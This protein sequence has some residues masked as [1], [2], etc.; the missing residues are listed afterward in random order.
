MARRVVRTWSGEREPVL[1]IGQ[2]SMKTG[3][4]RPGRAKAVEVLGGVNALSVE[5]CEHSPR[6]IVS[7]VPRLAARGCDD[8][9]RAQSLRFEMPSDRVDVFVDLAP[10]HWMQTLQRIRRALVLDSKGE[11]DEPDAHRGDLGAGH[12]PDLEHRVRI[13]LRHGSR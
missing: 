4:Q 2:R 8:A 1:E 7:F 3:D 5:P 11:I 13:G 12:L 9:R 10:E 6:P